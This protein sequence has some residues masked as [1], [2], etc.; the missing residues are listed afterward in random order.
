MSKKIW[1]VSDTAAE[2]VDA[3]DVKH[4]LGAVEYVIAIA[5][6]ELGGAVH[7][8]IGG[9]EGDD[10]VAQ[11]VAHL[12]DGA[13][14]IAGRAV[15]LGFLLAA[16]LVDT[17][18]AAGA[19]L[20]PAGEGV[21]AVA[22]IVEGHLGGG[23][24]LE[25]DVMPTAAVNPPPHEIEEA[26]ETAQERGLARADGAIEQDAL[27][28]GEQAGRS[29]ITGAGPK[30]ELGDDLA[31]ALV[32]DKA[33]RDLTHGVDKTEFPPKL[34]LGRRRKDTTGVHRHGR[35]SGRCAPC[36]LHLGMRLR[37]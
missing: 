37:G 27:G 3:D 12:Q 35:T 31:V 9:A 5:V 29:A 6:D 26:L 11:L 17:Q 36:T 33:G 13:D 19:P 8:D 23:A 1:F 7:V 16:Y 32:D 24:H 20:Q 34:A 14:H 30:E 2:A 22:G 21:H 10:L 18:M 25:A 28:R 4:F 15:E